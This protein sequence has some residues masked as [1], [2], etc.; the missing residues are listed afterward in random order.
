MA[1]GGWGLGLGSFHGAR[2][3]HPGKFHGG[4]LFVPFLYLPSISPRRH[5]SP[6]LCSVSFPSLSIFIILFGLRLSS[7]RNHTGKPPAAGIADR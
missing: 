1:V 7:P 3:Q 2:D 4:W 5:F 6:F